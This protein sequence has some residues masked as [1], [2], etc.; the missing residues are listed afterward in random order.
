MDSDVPDTL[1]VGASEHLEEMLDVAMDA[2]IGENAGEVQRGTVNFS[3]GHGTAPGLG[4]PNRAVGKGCFDACS[5]LGD[6]LAS[7]HGVVADFGV[8][9]LPGRQAYSSA[10]G[11]QGHCLAGG[12][13]AIQEISAGKLNCVARS[14]AAEP[15]SV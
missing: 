7:A 8:A 14:L 2:T 4:L 6:N 15:H 12:D 13:S 10:R 1:L 9:H 3:S 11:L 5:A